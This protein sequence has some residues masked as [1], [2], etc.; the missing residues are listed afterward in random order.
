MYVFELMLK[1][2]NRQIVIPLQADAVRQLVLQHGVVDQRFLVEPIG[3][4]TALIRAHTEAHLRRIRQV[5]SGRD[6]Y[7]GPIEDE[8]FRRR[9]IRAS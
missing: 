2:G 5:F 4:H 1:A 7:T 8:S 3:T 6:F 9:R